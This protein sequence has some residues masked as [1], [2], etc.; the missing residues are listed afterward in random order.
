MH[1]VRL[2]SAQSWHDSVIQSSVLRTAF[3]SQEATRDCGSAL[4]HDTITTRR[5]ESSSD[6]WPD[7]HEGATLHVITPVMARWMPLVYTPLRK[8]PV[9]LGNHFPSVRSQDQT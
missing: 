7:D 8:S 1:Q 3:A 4:P 2:L 9:L 6:D 5:R